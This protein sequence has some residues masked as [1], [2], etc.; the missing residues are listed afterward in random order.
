MDSL[1]LRP[2]AADDLALLH[3]ANTAEMTAHLNGPESSAELVARNER[4]VRLR[5]SGEARI[6]VVIENR[7]PLGS[8]G[9]W[10]TIWRGE[11]ALEAGWFV[12]PESQGRGVASAA[13]ALLVAD[14]HEHRGE[15]RLLTAFPQVENGPSNAVCKR[16]GFD[17]AGTISARF[18]GSALTMNE[19][20]LDLSRGV[21]S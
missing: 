15:R 11:A 18:R 17:F 5:S 12:L 7:E 1:A 2:W 21:G 8:I 10:Q 14:A 9:Y 6:F 20:V 19:W 16:A 3:R 13:L 4:Y